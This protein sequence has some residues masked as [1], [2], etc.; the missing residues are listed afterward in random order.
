MVAENI[1]ATIGIKIATDERANVTP[2]I[3]AKA[4]TIASRFAAKFAATIA[5]KIATEVAASIATKRA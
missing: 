1:A 2:E 5:A 4:E 3:V